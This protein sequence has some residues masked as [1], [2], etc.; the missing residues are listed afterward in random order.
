LNFF[1]I[2]LLIP[3]GHDQVELD[4]KGKRPKASPL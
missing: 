1:H 3:F 4:Q 2:D